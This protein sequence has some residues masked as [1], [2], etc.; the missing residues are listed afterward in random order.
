MNP[1]IPEVV[2]VLEPRSAV[3]W[4]KDLTQQGAAGV[5]NALV[6]HHVRVGV[7]HTADVEAVVMLG[8]PAH[9]Y[10]DERVK[11]FQGSVRRLDTAPDRRVDALQ[12]YF[13]LENGVGLF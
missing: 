11:F 5:L 3:S 10:L 2:L 4:R 6:I 1:A 13:D 12:G 8:F 7:V 9:R